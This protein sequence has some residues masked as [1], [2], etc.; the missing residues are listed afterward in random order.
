MLGFHR[1]MNELDRTLELAPDHLD[2]L[3]AKGTLLVRLPPFLGGDKSQG[4]QIL[5]QVIQ[6]EPASVN[7]RLSLAKSYCAKGRHDEAVSLAIEALHL[8]EAHHRDDFL[9][10]TRSVLSQLRATAT[11]AN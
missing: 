1:M 5:R 3:S 9:P 6:R 2:A 10:E 8:A 7:A 11:K 4:E